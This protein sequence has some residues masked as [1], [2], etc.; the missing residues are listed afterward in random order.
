M[1]LIWIILLFLHLNL[2]FSLLP[3]LITGK[4]VKVSIDRD[5]SLS[6]LEQQ[7][8]QNFNQHPRAL[9]GLGY[10]KCSKGAKH[11]LSQVEPLSVIDLNKKVKRG[12]I[13][14]ILNRNL[15]SME[16]SSCFDYFR[17]LIFIQKHSSHEVKFCIADVIIWHYT[18]V[19]QMN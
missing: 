8:I 5:G 13:Y 6:M 11:A 12:R 16:V 7:V 1:A 9:V 15:T 10:Y 4:P 3:F 2:F 18:R 14:I 19:K 17:R